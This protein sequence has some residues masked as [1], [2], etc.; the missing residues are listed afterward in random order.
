MMA[1]VDWRERQ[2]DRLISWPVGKRETNR[3]GLEG[4]RE[5]N[6]RGREG[7]RKRPKRGVWLSLRKIHHRK[8]RK[9][10][11]RP[12]GLRRIARSGRLSNGRSESLVPKT[13][14][15]QKKRAHKSSRITS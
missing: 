4:R 6:E 2:V 13:E 7:W 9:A 12:T 5:P 1:V 15:S 11:T 3:R 14:Q 10:G 8:V